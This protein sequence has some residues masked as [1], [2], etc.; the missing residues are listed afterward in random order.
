MCGIGKDNVIKIKTNDA[1]QMC[2]DDLEDKIQQSISEGCKPI[3]I[4]ATLGTTVFGAID[5]INKC[6]EIGN[7]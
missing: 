5:P 2:V 1:G 6:T 4:N 3:M 7:K